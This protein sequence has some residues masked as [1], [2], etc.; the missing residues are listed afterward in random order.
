M[1]F[2]PDSRSCEVCVYT[3]TSDHVSLRNNTATN[4]FNVI[5]AD[6]C[7]TLLCFV[8]MYLTLDF[9]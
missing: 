7:V 2:I 6:M 3:L 1:Q 4:E 8:Y 9:I 5:I